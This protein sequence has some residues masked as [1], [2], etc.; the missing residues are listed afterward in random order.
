MLE[1]EAAL[2]SLITNVGDYR[3]Y[4]GESISGTVSED[5][6]VFRSKNLA[7]DIQLIYRLNI[8]T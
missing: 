6:A 4:V 5:Y 2:T 1:S 7:T 3:E 8:G